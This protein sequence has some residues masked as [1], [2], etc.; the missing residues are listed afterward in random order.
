M[1]S[2]PPGAVLTK[3]PKNRIFILLALVL[4]IVF[5][6]TGCG[7]FRRP[8][9]PVGIY[10]VSNT[11]DLAAVHAAGFNAIAGPATKPL[12]DAAARRGVKVL[13]SPG[14]DAGVNFNAARARQVVKAFD[15]H[16]ALWAWYIV[17]E[18]DLNFVSPGE[19]RAAHRFLKNVPARK[20]TALVLFDGSD[21]ADY[22]DITDITMIDR[23]P[24]PWL[25]LANFPQHVRL[26]RSTV[27]KAKPVVAVLQA[28]DWTYYRELLPNEKEFR[29]P[30]Y[31]ELRCMTYAALVERA[32][33][34]FFYTFDGGGW[35][36]AEHPE[37]WNSL[38]QVVAEVR[39]RLPLF[40]A[41][42]VWWPFLHRFTDPAQRYNR[43]LSS[44]VA[45]SLVRVKRG[46]ASVPPGD[47]FVVVNNTPQAIEYELKLPVFV[48]QPVAVLGE[49]RSI[50]ANKRWLADHFEPYAVHIYGPLPRF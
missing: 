4:P 26:T 49:A 22:G 24:I 18:P 23:Y 5:I 37:T 44:S 1:Q 33:G 40:E 25:P 46:N 39:D 48:F 20:P 27:P 9:F 19:V 14:T 12:L 36:M 43:A 28:F 11:N 29:P 31:E 38:K 16:P 30:T 45:P 6:P 15:A 2:L 3:M 32:N 47:Y 10:G 50:A 21:A 7:S 17:D 13:A 34:L 35:K 42:H 8:F 41:E